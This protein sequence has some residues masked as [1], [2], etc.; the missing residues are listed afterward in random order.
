MRRREF[1][2]AL[3]GAAVWPK[4]GRAQQAMARIEMALDPAK[5]LDGEID[6]AKAWTDLEQS[7]PEFDVQQNILRET[8]CS[9]TGAPF[10][11][12]G[13]IFQGGVKS[14][15]NDLLLLINVMGPFGGRFGADRSH[16]AALAQYFLDEANCQGAR[17]LSE[18]DRSNLREIRDGAWPGS[19]G[20]APAREN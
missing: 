13:L 5:A 15:S 10:V 19:D 9:I 7:Q 16:P 8:G 14:R 6:M 11:I 20:S 17:G 12:E 2:W 1:I 3:G 4:T 18:E